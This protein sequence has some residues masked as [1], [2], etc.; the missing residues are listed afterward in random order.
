M[1]EDFKA[2]MFGIFVI[3][4]PIYAVGHI[5][6]TNLWQAKQKRFSMDM[7]IYLCCR[8]RSCPLPFL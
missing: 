1:K 7:G 5:V 6:R 2:S 4:M 8:H 3:S